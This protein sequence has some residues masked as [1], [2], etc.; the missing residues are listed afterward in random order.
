MQYWN[1]RNGQ[2]QY[3]NITRDLGTVDTG[4]LV[5]FGQLGGLYVEDVEITVA[6]P[7]TLTGG[8]YDAENVGWK[9]LSSATHVGHNGR[10]REGVRAGAV[11]LDG[12]TAPGVWVLG[13]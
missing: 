11:V 10:Y 9:R 13:I 1:Y 7:V 4:L 8:F 5:R 6:D 3:R 12:E 2:V